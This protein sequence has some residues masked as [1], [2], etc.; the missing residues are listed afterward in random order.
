MLTHCICVAVACT[1]PD[2]IAV[3][4]KGTCMHKHMQSSAHMSGTHMHR[5]MQ[6]AMHK[7]GGKCFSPQGP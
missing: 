3:N 5:D 1:E 4:T 2:N 6:F 7:V